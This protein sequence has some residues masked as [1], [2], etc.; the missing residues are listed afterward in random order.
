MKKLVE[1][2]SL[3]MRAVT[4]ISLFH[5]KNLMESEFASIASELALLREGLDLGWL[6]MNGALVLFMQAGFTLLEAGSAR[7]QNTV[8]IIVKNFGDFVLV[9]LLYYTIGWG[10]AFGASD[11]GFIGRTDYAVEGGDWGLFFFQN[12]FATTATTI[13][14][15]CLLER[16]HY[17]SYLVFASY[18][19]CFVYPVVCHWIWS[20]SGFLS[21]AN[22]NVSI[23]K[24]ALDFAGAG[25]VH[26]VGGTAGL[27]GATFLGPR[28]GFIDPQTGKV[29]KIEGHSLILRG[30]GCFILWFGWYG[31]N[32]G[33]TF[34]VLNGAHETI[35]LIAANSSLSAAC[36]GLG[37]FF[38]ATLLDKKVNVDAMLN[39]TLAGLVGITAGCANFEIWAA[40]LTGLGSGF[41][42]VGAS[43]L[44]LALKIDDPVNAVAVHGVGGAWGILSAGIF[45]SP[46]RGDFTG[47]IYGEGELLG[48]QL[49]ELTLILF[50]TSILS[51]LGFIAIEKVMKFRVTAKEEEDGLD[52]DTVAYP[53]L[54]MMKGALHKMVAL[55]RLLDSRKNQK[56]L[57]VFHAYL[58]RE[59]QSDSLDFLIAL[60]AY[61]KIAEKY[62]KAVN[63]SEKTVEGRPIEEYAEDLRKRFCAICEMYVFSE[64]QESSIVIPDHLRMHLEDFY[65]SEGT[66]PPTNVFDAVEQDVRNIL[67]NGAFVRFWEE[68]QRVREKY[69]KRKRQRRKDRSK[70]SKGSDESKKT[71]DSSATKKNVSRDASRERRRK[72]IHGSNSSVESARFWELAFER[73]TSEAKSDRASSDSEKFKVYPSGLVIWKDESAI[74][75]SQK[76]KSRAASLG[77]EESKNS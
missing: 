23:G 12:A 27:V 3:V 42:Y 4:A 47:L 73:D 29:M 34:G 24:G 25:P 1:E 45:A 63:Q 10:I 15:G 37:A 55:D 20:D 14:S 76:V 5:I 69:N 19:G 64:E 26:L 13:V 62:F 9:S 60:T 71:G 6:I 68:Y 36:G 33:S 66:V 58:Q 70:G 28:I 41:L 65:K 35:G 54:R 52:M 40:M 53:E 49:L 46:F 50:W 17:F 21:A 22:A 75:E 56:L 59:F 7:I 74:M 77:N 51:L 2:V 11:S 39:G 72:S 67:Q 18:L 8:S 61:S 32:C 30:F 16:T 43:M 44:I 57:W 31:F 38:L 48:I